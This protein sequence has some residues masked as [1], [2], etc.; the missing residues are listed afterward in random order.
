[1]LA[2]G[3]KKEIVENLSAIDPEKVILFGSYAY[4]TPHPD[5]DID[6]YIVT[7]EDFIPESY[8]E[9]L[10]IKKK[11]YKAL[12][13]FRKRYASDIIV[14]TL[15]SHQKFILSESS[16]SKEIMQKGVSLL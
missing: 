9:N 6:L 2:E 11:V 4:G 14:H 12:S 5:S 3:V 8:E 7:K 15:A 1:M 10:L 16:F 13:N